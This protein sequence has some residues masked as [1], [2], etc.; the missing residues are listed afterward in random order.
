MV[1]WGTQ[2]KT[3]KIEKKIVYVNKKLYYVDMRGEA[4]METSK[5]HPQVLGVVIGLPQDHL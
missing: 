2:R 4:G 1:Q 5:T 3:T